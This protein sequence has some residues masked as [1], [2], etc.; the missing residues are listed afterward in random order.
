MSIHEL[1]L[2]KCDLCSLENPELRILLKQLKRKIAAHL[3]RFSHPPQ[4]RT[5]GDMEGFQQLL[6]VLGLGQ[7]Q[8]AKTSSPCK[9]NRLFKFL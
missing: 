8:Q 7:S 4:E 1:L 5:A 2:S 6:R 3:A 9:H